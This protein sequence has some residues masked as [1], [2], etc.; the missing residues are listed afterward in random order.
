[1][2]KKKE[3]KVYNVRIVEDQTK[4]SL[5]LGQVILM[6]T[7]TLQKCQRFMKLIAMLSLLWEALMI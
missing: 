7:I 5:S 2:G 1:M 3:P 4:E 6:V